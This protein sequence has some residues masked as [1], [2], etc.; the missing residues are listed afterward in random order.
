MTRLALRNDG[1]LGEQLASQFSQEL[2]MEVKVLQNNSK[3]GI[4]L[5][6]YDKI[7]NKYLVIEVKSSEAGSFADPR[8]NPLT[9]LETRATS[10]ANGQGFWKVENTPTGIQDA[11]KDILKQLQAGATVT[12]IKLEVGIP[13]QRATG[14]PTI[15]VKSWK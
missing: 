6:A 3:H 13:L 8:T 12:G 10:A 9:F 2:G 5:Y 14:T 11:G 4:D 1:L 15:T 7:N